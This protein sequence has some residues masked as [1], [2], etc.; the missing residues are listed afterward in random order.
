MRD[1]GGD[2]GSGVKMRYVGWRVHNQ[3]GILIAKKKF[4]R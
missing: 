4:L 2:G 1:C 3:Y